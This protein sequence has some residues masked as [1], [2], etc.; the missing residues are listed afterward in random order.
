MQRCFLSIFS[1]VSSFCSGESS[2]KG[3]KNCLLPPDYSETTF[4]VS[5]W[6]TSYF[7][8]L[9]FSLQLLKWF[10]FFFFLSSCLLLIAFFFSSCYF[11][12]VS[13]NDSRVT[14]GPLT[15]TQVTT[16]PP[17]RPFTSSA[18][19]S[20]VRPIAPTSRPIGSINKHP[21]LRPITATVPVTRRPPPLPPH[22]P[23]RHFCEAKLVRGIQ[24]PITQRGET[25]DR[26]CPKGSL[27]KSLCGCSAPW[28]Y[29]PLYFISP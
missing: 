19:P 11:A 17:S 29:Q 23:E 18:S 27:G 28:K 6:E 1:S 26:P 5:A 3:H 20:T 22:N 13:L 16:T 2:L 14:S 4:E 15:T 10:F 9:I 25:V 21:D 8:F 12:I 7:I 24:W